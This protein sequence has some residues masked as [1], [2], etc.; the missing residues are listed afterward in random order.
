MFGHSITV[1]K[2][3][4]VYIYIYITTSKSVSSKKIRQL[5]FAYKNV[6]I[7]RISLRTR[8]KTYYNLIQFYSSLILQLIVKDRYSKRCQYKCMAKKMLMKFQ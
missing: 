2:Y 1:Q 4:E 8:P 3:G 5:K 6:S 7:N